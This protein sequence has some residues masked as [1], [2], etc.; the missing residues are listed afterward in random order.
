MKRYYNRVQKGNGLTR[1][2]CS[3]MRMYMKTNLQVLVKVSLML[4][5][6][7]IAK[8]KFLNKNKI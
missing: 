3:N 8:L 1:F 6:L 2:R 5:V 4:F 7:E